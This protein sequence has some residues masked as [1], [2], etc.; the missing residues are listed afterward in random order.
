MCVRIAIISDI[1]TNWIIFFFQEYEPDVTR[2][3]HFLKSN[4]LVLYSIVFNKSKSS[5]GQS[6]VVIN[7]YWN[8][9][10]RVEIKFYTV[11]LGQNGKFLCINLTLKSLNYRPTWVDILIKCLFISYLMLICS[12]TKV[13]LTIIAYIIAYKSL[14]AKLLRITKFVLK[15]SLRFRML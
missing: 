6:H 8:K 4:R 12:L 13:C 5:V 15:L 14:K 10:E 3:S 2:F 1:Q 11:P 7:D 9:N